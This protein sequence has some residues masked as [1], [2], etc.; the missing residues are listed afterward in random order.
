MSQNG[1]GVSRAES[2]TVVTLGAHSLNI[3]LLSTY[4]VLVL[5]PEA[6]GKAKTG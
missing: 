5:I 1:M 3:Y 6:G 4:Y 2:L